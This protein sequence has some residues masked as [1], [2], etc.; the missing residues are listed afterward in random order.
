M[1]MRMVLLSSLALA[2]SGCAVVDRLGGGRKSAAPPSDLATEFAPP[3]SVQPLGAAGYAPESLDKTSD[4][5][6]QAALA[7]PAAGGERQLGK[8]VVA[9]GPPAET[10]LWLQTALVKAPV[11]GRVTAPNGKSLAVELRPTSGAALMSL[12]AYQALG[13]GLTEL[14]EITIFAP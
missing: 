1:M 9:L 6:K 13:V 2:L 5:E 3:V 10:G 7:A 8:A 12:S 14:P 11:Q 4:A